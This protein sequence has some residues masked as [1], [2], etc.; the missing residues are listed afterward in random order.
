MNEEEQLSVPAFGDDYSQPF[1]I[2][3]DHYL[4]NRGYEEIHKIIA[5]D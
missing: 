3:N 4:K 5:D 1:R 2:P